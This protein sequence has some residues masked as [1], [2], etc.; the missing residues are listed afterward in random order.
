MASHAL[1]VPAGSIHAPR[2]SQADR[3]FGRRAFLATL[4]AVCGAALGTFWAVQLAVRAEVKAGVVRSLR[5]NQQSLEQAAERRN[6]RDYLALAWI[7][8]NPALRAAILRAA[9]SHSTG[10]SHTRALRTLQKF[11]R[12]ARD[13]M[14]SDVAGVTAADGRLLAAAPARGPA[15]R[16]F[17]GASGGLRSGVWDLDGTLCSVITA[18]V[19]VRGPVALVHEGRVVR[20]TFSA[21]AQLLDFR[22]DCLR[23]GCELRMNGENFLVIPVSRAAA[24]FALSPEDQILSF[25]S[26]DAAADQIIGGFRMRLPVLCV[27]IALLALGLAAS[28]SHALSRPLHQLVARLERSQASGR[29]DADF[30]EDSA[31]R[32]VNLLAAAINRAAT[33]VTHSNERL[34]QAAVDFVETMAQALDAR[35][36]CT[37]GH[38]KRVS[39]YATAIAITMGLSPSEI[40]T[41]RLGAR[42]HDIGKIG[43]SDTLLRKPSH[44]TPEEYDII[45]LHPQIGRKILEGVAAFEPYLP[46]VELHHEDFDGQ[47]YPYGL[48]GHEVPLAVRIVR[49]ADVFDALTTDRSYR[50]AMPLDSACELIESHAGVKFDPDVVRAL[51]VTLGDLISSEISSS[52]LA[53][54][55]V[56]VSRL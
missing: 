39:E 16:L 29:W 49:V 52:D 27:V 1:E 40:E 34:D 51:R 47:G 38:S 23:A 25:Q 42:L 48:K 55:G 6:Q 44:L 8:A 56:T 11:S 30:P 32:E 14:R 17:Q 50:Q 53:L 37:A 15:A 10:A 20:S 13:A 7:S 2:C 19:C 24:G 26:I 33:A 45:K 4:I 22:P 3:S 28:V 5:E 43:I 54:L 9:Q 12:S 36:P 46:I 21:A 35:D 31:T 41:I 18:P